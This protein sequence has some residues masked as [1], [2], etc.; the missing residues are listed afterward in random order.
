MKKAMARDPQRASSKSIE[1]V[2]RVGSLTSRVK[3]VSQATT[4][5]ALEA[6]A[7]A[8]IYTTRLVSGLREIALA[9]EL[10]EHDQAAEALSGAVAGLR[11]LADILAMVGRATGVQ[12]TP[13]T[14][15]ELGRIALCL[16][17]V[18]QS[19]S[20]RELR[21][22]AR[23]IDEELVPALARLAPSFPQLEARVAARA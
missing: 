12:T 9:F 16:K 23:L 6:L 17:E 10:G 7:A 5:R 18:E 22:V 3:P 15:Q 20:R 1:R 13:S 11:C 4:E 21:T 14:D 8:D 2:T 19:Y